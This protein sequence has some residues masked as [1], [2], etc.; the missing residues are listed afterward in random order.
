MEIFTNSTEFSPARTFSCGQ[1]FRWRALP[2]GSFEGIA[3]GRRITVSENGGVVRFGGFPEREERLW[4]DYFDLDTDYAEYIARL[5]ADETLSAACRASAGIHILR[6]DPFETLISFIISQNNNIPRIT[7]IVERLCGLFGEE[8][9]PFVQPDEAPERRAIP[10]EKQLCNA[11][12]S[13]GAVAENGG[14]TAHAAPVAVNSVVQNAENGGSAALETSADGGEIVQIAEAAERRAFPTAKR[15]DGVEEGDLAPLRAGFRARYIADAVR[16]VNSG[17]I[18][19]GEID[20]LP[21]DKARE[22]L[23]TIVG[24]GD[25]V[26]DCVLLFAFRK[27]DAFPKDVWVKRVMAQ[28]YP[29]GLPDCTKG[30]EGIAQQYLF[31]YIRNVHN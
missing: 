3:H 25:K 13:V 19:F 5:S 23:K 2:D 10:A 7:G 30:I 9:A 22:R 20:A 8:I 14:S 18:D 24:V 26:A 15:L 11:V 21:L 1:C 12:S 28:Y 27:P 16:R 6:Q 17:E 31:D 29:H 4:R